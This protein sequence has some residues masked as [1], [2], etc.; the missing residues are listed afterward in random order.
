M[1]VIVLNGSPRKV[2][3]TAQLL[4]EAQKG[5]ESVGAE[6]EYFDLFDLKFTGCRSCLACKLKGATEPWKCAWKDEL[7]PILEK[8]LASD[9]IITGSPIYFGEPTAT[10]RAFM[11]RAVFPALSYNDYSSVFTGRVDVDVFLTMNAPQQY[12]DNSYASKM[13]EYFTPFRFLNGQ[14][15]IFPVCDTLQV[16]DYSKY[17]MSGFSEEHKKSVYETEFPKALELAFKVGAGQ[18]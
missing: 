14:T 5:A 2:W 17:E 7:T 11:E 18:A 4:K 16:K 12:Y 10:F 8:V 1:K 15:R 9:R 13:Q 3:M 6:V